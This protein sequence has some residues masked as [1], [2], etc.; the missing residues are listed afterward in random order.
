M[1]FLTQLVVRLLVVLFGKPPCPGC[2]LCRP[3]EEEVLLFAV[4]NG[5]MVLIDVKNAIIQQRVDVPLSRRGERWA[6]MRSMN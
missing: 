1:R 6:Y 2:P 5:W 3:Q 4:A